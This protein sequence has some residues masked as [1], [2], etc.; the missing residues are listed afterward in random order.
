MRFLYSSGAP[1]L[2]GRPRRGRAAVAR[3]GL[4]PKVSLGLIR[5]RSHMLPSGGFFVKHAFRLSRA[6]AAVFAL[7]AVLGGAAAS[8]AQTLSSSPDTAIFQITSTTIPAIPTPT[9]SPTPTATPT[10]GATPAPVA[11]DSFAADINGSGRFVVIEST[12]DIATD[13]SATRNNVDGNN[14]IFLFDYAQRRIFQITNTTSVLKDTTKS[15]I[16]PTNIDVN[17]VNL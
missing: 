8:R 7:A 3:K 12:G 4:R 9:P 17:V 13:R 5:Q 10:P 15:P 2:E 1:D 16:D 11:R 14:E 6:C